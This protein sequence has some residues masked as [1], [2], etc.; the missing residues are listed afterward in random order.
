MNYNCNK[1]Q[2]QNYNIPRIR[3]C[4]KI[5]L[6]E[7]LHVKMK[8]GKNFTFKSPFLTIKILDQFIKI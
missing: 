3:K 2:D 5:K 4:A 1:T 8:I 7:Y 6:Q